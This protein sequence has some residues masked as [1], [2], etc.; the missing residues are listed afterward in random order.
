MYGKSLSLLWSA[1]VVLMALACW[2]DLHDQRR[3]TEL[4]YHRVAPAFGTG[5]LGSH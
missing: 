1:Y 4:N 2:D 5:P 3:P